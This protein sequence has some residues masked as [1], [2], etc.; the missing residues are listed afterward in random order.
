MSCPFA[1]A[2]NNFQQTGSE[3]TVPQTS[4]R[5]EKTRTIVHLMQL[6][7]A[8]HEGL[9]GN[10]F[11]PTSYAA[12]T[13]RGHREIL[14]FPGKRGTDISDAVITE[15]H[16]GLRGM[17]GN[18]GK[19]LDTS[20]LPATFQQQEKYLQQYFSLYRKRG[21]T[22][23][24][25]YD[26]RTPY[27]DEIDHPYM[28]LPGLKRGLEDHFANTPELAKITQDFFYL[29]KVDS[30]ANRLLAKQNSIMA[31]QNTVPIKGMT[32]PVPNRIVSDNTTLL[33]WLYYAG[34][35]AK[36]INDS[37][38]MPACVGDHVPQALGVTE[39]ILDHFFKFCLAD[40]D[41]LLPPFAKIF[42]DAFTDMQERV[43]LCGSFK[44]LQRKAKENA[45]EG[46][47]PIILDTL[48]LNNKDKYE[49][50]RQ[51]ATAPTQLETTHL[52]HRRTRS[53]CPFHQKPQI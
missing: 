14:I 3:T 27:D 5:S 11:A 40:D 49:A 42:A 47:M 20:R 53:K 23:K 46:Q 50:A 44:T 15:L 25:L 4:A 38:K 37:I 24:T 16:A 13:Q 19:C 21:G 8:L 31:T 1:A 29:E 18:L 39:D 30:Q 36:A 41:H 32:D 52:G 48:G 6:N 28:E 9:S 12:S 33:P 51:R 10:Q 35:G 26:D 43:A 22:L 17:V 45:C 2:R 7:N 34:I